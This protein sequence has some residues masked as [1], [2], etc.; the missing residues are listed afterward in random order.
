[1]NM[2]EPLYCSPEY[3]PLEV[4]WYS[5]GSENVYLIQ[6][7]PVWRVQIERFHCNDMVS[8]HIC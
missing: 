5:L 2:V 7:S 4:K 6:R 8:R 3:F 1:M